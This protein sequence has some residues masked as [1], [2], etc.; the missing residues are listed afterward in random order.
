M[1]NTNNKMFACDEPDCDYVSARKFNLERH[2]LYHS[3]E[4]VNAY[5]CL[6]CDEPIKDL[7]NVK[8]HRF[9]EDH[10][11][12]VREMFPECCKVRCCNILG[13]SALLKTQQKYVNKYIIK[14]QTTS[15][16]KTVKIGKAKVEPVE[17]IEEEEEQEVEDFTEPI[18]AC[19]KKIESMMKEIDSQKLKGLI[20]KR[21]VDMKQWTG[22]DEETYFKYNDL[23][24]Q[25]EELL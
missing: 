7:F 2:Q 13:V 22:S 24:S 14:K 4:Q 6:A 10:C 21:I 20:G 12:N 25:L 15:S 8:M 16:S 18:K 1:N 17:V 19:K 23:E 5:Y 9:N 3:G 11:E